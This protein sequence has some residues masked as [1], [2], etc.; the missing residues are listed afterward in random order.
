MVM[1]LPKKWP[2]VTWCPVQTKLLALEV[3]DNLAQNLCVFIDFLLFLSHGC[4]LETKK[5]LRDLSQRASPKCFVGK[6]QDSI[7]LQTCRSL[8]SCGV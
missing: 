8:Y 2:N 3:A 4:L 7:F 5:A 6:M 1:S